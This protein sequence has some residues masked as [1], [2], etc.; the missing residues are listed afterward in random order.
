M[1]NIIQQLEDLKEWSQNPERYE[2]RLAFR[3]SMGTEAGTIPAEFDELSPQEQQYYQNPPFSTHPDFLGAK[4]GSAQLVDHG[5]GRQGY[6]GVKGKSKYKVE[7]L[8]EATKHYTDGKYKNWDELTEAASKIKQTEMRNAPKEVRD[9]YHTRIGIRNNL[10]NN[11][12]K[13][14]IPDPKGGQFKPLYFTEYSDKAFLKDLKSNKGTYEIATDYYLKNKK[15]IQKQM[16]GNVEYTRPISYLSKVLSQR[17]NRNPDIAEELIRFRSWSDAQKGPKTQREYAKKVERLLPLAIENGIVPS[18]IDTHSKY[19]KWAKKQKIDPLLKLFNNMEKVG[20]EHIAGISRAV[21]IMDYKSLGEIVPLLGDKSVNFEKGLLYDRPMTGLGKNILKSDNIK[22]QKNNLKALNNMSK[23]AAEMYNTIAVKYKLNPEKLNSIGGQMLERVTKGDPLSNTLLRD[24]DLVMKQYAASGGEKRASFKH[25]DPDVKKTIKLYEAGDVKGGIQLLKK[26]GYGGGCKAS[27][28]R[29]G[30]ADAGDVGSGQMKCI[31][32]DVKKT[33]DDLK[34]PNV[35]VRAKALT[36]QRKALQLAKQIPKIGKILK[37]GVQMGT[38]A[39]TAPL[40]WLGLTSGIGYAIEGIVEGGFY[41]NARRKGYSHEQAMAETFSPRLIKEGAEGKSTKDVPWY[42]GSE[43]LREKELY[44][45]KGKNEFIDVEN[46]PQMQDPT[47]GKVVGT[48]GKVKQYVDALKEQDRIYDLIGKKEA[49]KG[50]PTTTDETLFIPGDLDAASADVQDLARSG[51]YRRVDQ[52]LKPEGMAA[53]AYNTAV[54]S[55][56]GKD[57]QRKKEYLEK[58]D[59]GA[60]EREEKIL[61]RP[62]QLEKRYQQMEEKYPTYTREQI[63]QVLKGWEANTPWN[64]GFA[65]G[66]KGYDE[67]GEWLKNYDKS[68]YF[69]ENFRTE[70]AGGGIAGI[71]RPGA[72]PP[73][74][75]PMPQGGGLSSQYNRV[76]KLTE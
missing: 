24:A 64:V 8:N 34:S 3:G 10:K 39:I 21:D 75:G 29:V 9:A 61:S 54:E 6:Q 40:K 12:G 36:K 51:A 55:Q 58:Y 22:I 35:E 1:A 53:Q 62:R 65:S 56:L 38:A 5:P 76:K 68:A 33:R 30:F 17:K 41:D 13:F 20:I 37:T 28:G 67:M 72:V 66:V 50:E 57:L 52:T 45:I 7:E 2:R 27:G 70:K 4:G 44:E 31:M 32:K 71:R 42:G 48:R 49:L 59:P 60:L 11:K 69:A 19:F 15:F 23:E 74:S 46:R 26:M 47:F 43:K 16:I 73:E 14:V 25:L 63:E 18:T